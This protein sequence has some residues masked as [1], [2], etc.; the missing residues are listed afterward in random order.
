MLSELL[1]TIA[2]W[3][4]VV[5]MAI[6][7]GLFIWKKLYR[8][9]PL[10]FAYLIATE[11][12]AWIRY[13]GLTISSTVFFYV[14]W[15][16]DIVLTLFAFAAIYELFIGNL[17]VRFY[18]VRFYR[19]LFPCAGIAMLGFTLVAA[20][21]APKLTSLLVAIHTFELLRAVVLMFFVLL[22]L[23]MG[24][25][26]KKQEFGITLGFGI[27]ASALVAYTAIIMRAPHRR[28]TIAEMLLRIAYLVACCVWL[29]SF[30][31]PDAPKAEE[32]GTL[33]P[34][35]LNEAKKWEGALK[36]WLSPTKK[37]Q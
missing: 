11:A 3:L 24:R 17:F 30:L 37:R 22:V 33:P 21:R 16:C 27:Y 25:E 14:Y 2:S 29:I 5:F 31:L 26:W 4:P 12:V 35:V 20:L 10:F 36:D 15:S 28:S 32:P 34:D 23:A 8:R 1:T 6:L 7:V 19:F 13:V 18:K 9:F